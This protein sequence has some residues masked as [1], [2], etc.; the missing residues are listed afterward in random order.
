M[1]NKMKIKHL[2]T[3]IFLF[4]FE[5]NGQ[6][7][8][9]LFALNN[10]SSG[11]AYFSKIEIATGNITNYQ[12]VAPG[13]SSNYSYCIDNQAQIFYFCNGTNLMSIDPFNGNILSNISL[14][15]SSTAYLLDIAFNPCDTT[16]YGMIFDNGTRT[17][18]KYNINTSTMTPISQLSGVAGE[19][20]ID[21]IAE[22]YICASGN[23]SGISLSSGQIL[24]SSPIIN[25]PGE[26]FG[27]ISF[28]CTTSEIF[29]TSANM[30]AGMK[31]LSTIDPLTGIVSHVSNIGWNVGIWKPVGGGSCIDQFSGNYY[32]SAA[33]PLIVGANTVNGNMV[34][35]QP[36]SSGNL[37]GIRHFSECNCTS[38]GITITN[39]SFDDFTIGPNP[40]N[41]R[42][43]I[44]TDNSSPLLFILYDIASR[45]LLYK[46]FSNILSLN[47]ELLSKG[48]YLYEIS[49]N[50][51]VIKKGKIVKE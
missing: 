18:A 15:I 29:G 10:A 39:N 19:S 22:I 45:K 46:E 6:I 28:K 3:F 37:F 23:I 5:S 38:T 51:K 42:V 40:F 48:V 30:S 13:L 41:D 24:F 26:S 35:N 31:Y 44:K 49:N 1:K 36:I 21:P 33:G 7:S 14:P 20:F 9:Y 8:N 11:V 17:F 12:L 2:I 32:Y 25:L 34:Y 43:I 4:T 50:N 27:H 47:T 16:I